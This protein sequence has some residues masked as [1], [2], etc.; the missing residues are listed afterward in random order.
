MVTWSDCAIHF[1]FC[2]LLF[3]SSWQLVVEKF[4]PTGFS[5]HK[6]KW[7]WE[8]MRGRKRER[9]KCFSIFLRHFRTK[10]TK[11]PLPCESISG[12]CVCVCLCEFYTSSSTQSSNCVSIC[13]LALFFQLLRYTPLHRRLFCWFFRKHECFFDP[14][15]WEFEKRIQHRSV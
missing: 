4:V 5:I 11:F 1:V 7:K 13:V 12:V 10:N 15:T 6:W 3:F 9:E 2:H 14:I 8:R